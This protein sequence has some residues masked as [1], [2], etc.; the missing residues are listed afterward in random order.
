MDFI[1]KDFYKLFLYIRNNNLEDIIKNREILKTP[2]LEDFSNEDI[3]IAL[4]VTA[5]DNQNFAVLNNLINNDINKKNIDYEI[6]IRDILTTKRLQFIIRNESKGFRISSNLIKF[7]IKNCL[8]NYLDIIFENFKF[9]DNEFIISFCI[10]SKNKIPKPNLF[11][12]NQILKEKY[13][14]SIV[15]GYINDKERIIS[16]YLVNCSSEGKEHLVKYLVEH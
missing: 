4:Y 8:S 3:Q 11:L 16:H 13:K 9:Y 15:N 1:K 5:I 12:N 10:L 2:E 6:F 14:I 7:F